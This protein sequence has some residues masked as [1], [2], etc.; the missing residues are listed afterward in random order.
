MSEKQTE[1]KAL[2]KIHNFALQMNYID[3]LRSVI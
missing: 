3:D 2:K 1:T